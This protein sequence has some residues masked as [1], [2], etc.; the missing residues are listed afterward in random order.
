MFPFYFRWQHRIGYIFL[1]ASMYYIYIAD[2]LAVFPR[3]QFLVIRAE[4]YCRNRSRILPDVYQ[5]LGLR[6]VDPE[7]LNNI[8]RTIVNYRPPKRP[9]LNE[10][11]RLLNDFFRPFNAMLAE[12]F[13]DS[14]F[15]WNIR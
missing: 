3:D 8:N 13:N 1:R 7:L 2:W 10:T 5:F 12:L 11:R 15:L 4:D 6:P 14:K 9:M